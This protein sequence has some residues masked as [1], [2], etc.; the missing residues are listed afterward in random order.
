MHL[1]FFKEVFAWPRAKG[2]DVHCFY[3]MKALAELGHEISL[4]TVT[5]PPPEALSGLSLRMTRVLEG[6]ERANGA[7]L[8]P[9]TR[10]QERFRSYWGIEPAAIKAVGA[11]ARDSGAEVVVAVGLS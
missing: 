5:P 9:L 10:F 4:V 3:M 6:I 11:A 8:L 1:L 2:H 7:P